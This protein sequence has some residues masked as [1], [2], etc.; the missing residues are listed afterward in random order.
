[1]H[2]LYVVHSS[3]PSEA[4]RR[5]LALKGIPCK[6]VE[7]LIPTHAPLM[8]LRFG[9]RT[10]PALK[11][12]GGEKIS[13]SR[14]I[15][16][17][18]DELVA[19]PPLLPPD[20]EPALRAAVLEAERWGDEVLQPLVRRIAWSALK[21]APGAIPSYQ[22]A[23]RLP[24]LPRPVVKLVA[25]AVIA[26]E[27]RMHGASDDV[28]RAD[29]RALPAHLDHVDCMIAAG[30]LGRHSDQPSAADLQIGS[31]LRLLGTI[32]DARPLLA[33][34][35]GEALAT[36]LFADFPGD[37]PAGTFPPDWLAR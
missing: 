27:R 20:R 13:G 28:V 11:L 18:L 7:L 14:A 2:K 25:P 36:K 3:H 26:V 31:S 15:M 17:K 34:R 21:R 29:L 19:D 4:V 22:A 5:A 8:R 37:V 12:D 35:P 6:T 10:V 24:R 33:G 1:M 9:Q 30:V 32:G 16:R 23:S